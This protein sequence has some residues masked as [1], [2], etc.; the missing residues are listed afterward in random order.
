MNVIFT[1][2]QSHIKGLCDFRRDLA[3]KNRGMIRFTMVPF[4]YIV[5]IISQKVFK[6]F[7]FS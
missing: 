2:L 3:F 5:V 6:N 4:K 7:V 1:L